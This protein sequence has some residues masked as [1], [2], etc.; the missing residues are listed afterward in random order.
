ME[1]L[2]VVLLHQGA[3]FPF[4]DVI[5]ESSFMIAGRGFAAGV[6]KKSNFATFLDMRKSRKEHIL[7]MRRKDSEGN[8][9]GNLEFETMLD[10]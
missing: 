9:F 4:F 5:L 10:C 6:Q 3:S 7:L 1:I 8:C 2:C